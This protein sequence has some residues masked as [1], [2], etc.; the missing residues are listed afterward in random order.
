MTD[1][2]KEIAG[3]LTEI[4]DHLREG[5]KRQAETLE[6][7]RVQAERSKAV[8]GRSVSL[9]EL[10]IR[11]QRSVVL[12]VVPIVVICIGVLGWLIIKY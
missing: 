1:E 11:R 5:S 7:L 2:S 3:L 12:L 4:L 6:F 9:Q 10:A 8:I